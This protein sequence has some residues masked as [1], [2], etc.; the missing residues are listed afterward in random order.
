MST[1]NKTCEKDLTEAVQS[2]TIMEERMATTVVPE[3]IAQL[4][5]EFKQD[6]SN[7]ELRNRLVEIY[8]PLV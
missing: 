6:M 3:D 8:L 1:P 7:Q 5:I 4:W 2:S